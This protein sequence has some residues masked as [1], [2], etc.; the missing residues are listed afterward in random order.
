VRHKTVASGGLMRL[1]LTGRCP[2]LYHSRPEVN[3]DETH[4]GRSGLDPIGMVY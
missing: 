4:T 2:L 1:M 3:R